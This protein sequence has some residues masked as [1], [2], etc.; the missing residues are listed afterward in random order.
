MKT[1]NLFFMFPIVAAFCGTSAFANWQYSGEYTYNPGYYDNGMRTVVSVRAGA[2]FLMSKMHNDS[3]TIVSHY[4]V[5]YDTGA[6]LPASGDCSSMYDGFV[7]AGDGEFKSLKINKDLSDFAFTAGASVGITLPEK[8]QWRFELGW[9]H[10]S[11][12]DY[13]ESPLF[14][15]DMTLTGGDTINVESGAVQSTVASDVVSLMAFYDFFSGYVKPLH[16]IIPYIGLGFG[17]SNS[18]TVLNLSDPWADLSLSED[19]SNFGEPNTNGIIQFYQSKTDTNNVAAV[20][21]LGF[22][23]GLMDNLFLDFGARVAYIPKIK[24]ALKNTDDTRK[25]DLF[26]AKNALYTNVMLGLRFEF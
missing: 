8:P 7:D 12:I 6:V 13:N 20:G 14:T 9:D 11:E 4:C 19:L 15:G 10:F 22:A 17:Y 3:G 1:K 26:S 24:Y 23:Y 16:T 25:L 21:A 2:T 5:N 18:R